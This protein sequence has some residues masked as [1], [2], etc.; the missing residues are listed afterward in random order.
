M[1]QTNKQR[2]ISIV[3]PLSVIY[4]DL[5]WFDLFM[6]NTCLVP[7]DHRL[8]WIINKMVNGV[9]KKM[10]WDFSGSYIHQYD[11]IWLEKM[12]IIITIIIITEK[13]RLHFQILTHWF[14]LRIIWMKWMKN[15]LKIEYINYYLVSSW[16]PICHMYNF[17][18]I[19]KKVKREK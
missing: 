17:S 19:L 14:C 5:I 9:K 3:I 11:T 13:N 4:D 7:F 18:S 6:I 8:I 2:K 12:I 1:K 10:E 15:K 16:I